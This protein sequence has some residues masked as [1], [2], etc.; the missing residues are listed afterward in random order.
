MGK[1][2]KCLLTSVK[3]GA[4]TSITH[5]SNLHCFEKDRDWHFSDFFP[6]S[7]PHHV[8]FSEGDSLT[9]WSIFFSFWCL[10]Q[11][12]FSPTLTA[13]RLLFMSA[14]GT[15]SHEISHIHRIAI[16]LHHHWWVGKQ[17]CP[18]AASLAVSLTNIGNLTK[19]FLFITSQLT[20]L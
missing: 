6:L 8:I 14:T 19:C 11:Q 17:R 7:C 20:K 18:A 2:A 1:S 12:V 13:L 4:L 10:S 5:G 16:F 9:L 15:S 3:A